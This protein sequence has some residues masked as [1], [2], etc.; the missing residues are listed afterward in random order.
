MA[1]NI[2]CVRLDTANFEAGDSNYDV[3]GMFL[4]QK[5]QILEKFKVDIHNVKW[6]I[7]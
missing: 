7:L 2:C 5:Q 4:W 3:H 1:Q 6:A